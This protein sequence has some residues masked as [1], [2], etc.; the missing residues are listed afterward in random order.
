MKD[1]AVF[2]IAVALYGSVEYYTVTK[3]CFDHYTVVRLVASQASCDS[4]STAII[5]NEPA[6]SSG[7][8]LDASVWPS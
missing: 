4:S 5:I 8:D 7:I 3:A 2:R 1:G 6:M